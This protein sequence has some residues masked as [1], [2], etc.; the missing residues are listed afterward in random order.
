MDSVSNM[1]NIPNADNDIDLEPAPGA[2][3]QIQ[4]I[5]APDPPE[6]VLNRA[7]S[8]IFGSI[9]SNIK[10]MDTASLSIQAG[11]ATA[12]M[13]DRLK[14]AAEARLLAETTNR[15]IKEATNFFLAIGFKV[16][17]D[18][19]ITASSLVPDSMRASAAAAQPD[20]ELDS[21]LPTA[22]TYQLTLKLSQQQP[23]RPDQ[24]ID[25]ILLGHGLQPIWKETSA[26]ECS[27]RYETRSMLMKA[28]RILAGASIGGVKLSSF[29]AVGSTIRSMY[30][31]RTVPIPAFYIQD[32]IHEN[33]IVY[34]KA[35]SFLH[36]HNPSWFPDEDVEAI[37]Y[38]RAKAPKNSKYPNQPHVSVKLFISQ[39]SYRHF[40]RTGRNAT[41]VVF[42]H[43]VVPI[44][45]EVNVIQCWKC[46][47]YGHLSSRCRTFRCRSCTSD[48]EETSKTVKCPTV[49]SPVCRICVNNNALLNDLRAK[50]LSGGPPNFPKWEIADTNHLATSGVCKAQHYVKEVNL[51]R[52]K[53]AAAKRRPLPEFSFP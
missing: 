25:Q 29:A 43:A 46:C 22:S 20:Y 2:D 51:Q 11:M 33:E 30:A 47:E 52:L 39:P 27:V 16:K 15:T 13:D 32:W 14:A 9:S 1:V 31:I 10:M 17:D 12:S 28:K 6:V 3:V 42:P 18:L 19:A 50:G 37:E 24:I 8:S 7:V 23:L 49:E 48:H 45:E 40:L 35:L 38:F 26:L 41:A 34:D 36:Q 4:T 53:V 21:S 44:W 5:R